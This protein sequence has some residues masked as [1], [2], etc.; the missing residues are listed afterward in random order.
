MRPVDAMSNEL[1]AKV[2]RYGRAELTREQLLDEGERVATVLERG[3]LD[4]GRPADREW[5][6]E[7]AALIR[8]ALG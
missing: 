2:L 3:T 6:L 4:G 5:W 8:G 7:R 1:L